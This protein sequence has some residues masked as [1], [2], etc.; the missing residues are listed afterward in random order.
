M[1]VDKAGRWLRASSDR[2]DE[3]NQEQ[4]IDAYIA[5]RGYEPGKTYTARDKSASKNE[6]LPLL[7]EAL[8]DMAAG[9]ISVL[10]V[11]NTDRIDRTENLGQILKLAEAAGGRIESVTEP[12]LADL[13]G[14]GAKS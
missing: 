9:R 14:L 4:G 5:A 13:S 6:H 7:R 1:S 8:A 10:V 3:L 12:W 2:Q 11:R